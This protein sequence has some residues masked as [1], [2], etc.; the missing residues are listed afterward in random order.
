[1]M[2]QCTNVREPFHLYIPVASSYYSKILWAMQWGKELKHVE[3]PKVA[4]N[5]G[6]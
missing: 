4:A 6:S 1:M 2:I 3:T 5:A